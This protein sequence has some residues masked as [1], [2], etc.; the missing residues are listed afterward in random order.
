MNAHLLQCR[1]NIVAAT[2]DICHGDAGSNLYIRARSLI[3]R[4]R[5]EEVWPE[6]GVTGLCVSLLKL[7]AVQQRNSSDV[8]VFAFINFWHHIKADSLLLASLFEMQFTGFGS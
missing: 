1:G 8:V 6:A 2:F 5:I 3:L 7:F 4:R